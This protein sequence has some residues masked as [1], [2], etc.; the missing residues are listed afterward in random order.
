VI[1][2]YISIDEQGGEREFLREYGNLI[3][4]KGYQW[5]YDPTKKSSLID[6]LVYREIHAKGRRVYLD[7]R[8]DPA[9]LDFGLL[10]KEAHGYLERSGALLP[11]PIARLEH[12]NPQAIQLYQKNGID[13]YQEP[14]EI[15]ICAR[16][17][18]PPQPHEHPRAL[19]R[20]GVRPH[21]PARRQPPGQ[22]LPARDPGLRPQ[23]GGGHFGQC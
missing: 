10:G 23:G 15:D 3:F 17:R 22:Q 12:M 13:L 11:T 14:L 21:R 16:A 8:S 20:R 19:R 2:R 18:G 9:G 5:P 7:Y 6:E 1:P 4:L